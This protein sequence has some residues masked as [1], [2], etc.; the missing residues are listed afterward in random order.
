MIGGGMEMTS[1][2]ATEVAGVTDVPA[3]VGVGVWSAP[4]PLSPWTVAGIGVEALGG[5]SLRE[6]PPW[7]E[8]VGG[9]GTLAAVLLLKTSP[10]SESSSSEIISNTL[11]PLFRGVGDGDA[12]TA[13]GTAAMGGG[14]PGV[15]RCGR[16]CG[17]GEDEPSG[18]SVV[19][20]AVGTEGA[21]GA[22]ALAARAA[23]IA[24]ANIILLE[25]P[26]TDPAFR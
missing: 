6:L 17:G 26:I 8:A 19:R 18:G 15:C 12:A 24:F 10:P 4:S 2:A 16:L 3:G 1:G 20:S 25:A 21:W 7:G 14:E 22:S 11:F 23:F 13:K 5:L 9:V